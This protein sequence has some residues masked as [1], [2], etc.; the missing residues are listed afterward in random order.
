M[1]CSRHSRAGRAGMGIGHT[2]DAALM[3]MRTAIEVWPIPMPAL[4]ARL[5]PPTTAN[6]AVG[7]C[8]AGTPLHV[9]DASGSAQE[10]R[11]SGDRE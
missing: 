10:R 8:G 6:E 3:W 2:A 1:A 4:H 9:P 5:L 7:S 11:G